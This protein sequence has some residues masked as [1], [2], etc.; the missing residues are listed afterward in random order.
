MLVIIERSRTLFK[1]LI[2]FAILSIIAVGI[3]YSTSAKEVIQENSHGENRHDYS[4]DTETFVY[5]TLEINVIGYYITNIEYFYFCECPLPKGSDALGSFLVTDE[6]GTTLWIKDIKGGE[7]AKFKCYNRNF[8]IQVFDS[9]PYIHSAIAYSFSIVAR[10]RNPNISLIYIGAGYGVIFL[11]VLTIQ[12]I[13]R[14]KI[15]DKS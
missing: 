14:R 9:A 1:I 5:C 15:I 7:K 2:V 11:T 3:S 13:L 4:I 12:I 6:N 8:S 10:L